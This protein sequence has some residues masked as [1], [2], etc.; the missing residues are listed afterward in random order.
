MGLY[1]RLLHSIS[2]KRKNDR[3]EI[4]Q[5]HSR[6]SRILPVNYQSA[7]IAKARAGVIAPRRMNDQEE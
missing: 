7:H 1:V 4:L 3:R 6:F 5:E 2:G